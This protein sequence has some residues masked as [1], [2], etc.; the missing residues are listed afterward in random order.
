MVALVDENVAVVSGNLL[1]ALRPADAATLNPYLEPWI[2][3]RG[4]VGGAWLHQ[5]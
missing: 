2:G 1:R 4:D 5:P 3:A